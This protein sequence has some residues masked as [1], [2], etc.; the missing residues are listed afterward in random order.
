MSW[1]DIFKKNMWKG[2]GYSSSYFPTAARAAAATKAVARAVGVKAAPVARVIGS[3]AVPIIGKVAAGTGTAATATKGAVL[4]AGVAAG[5]SLVNSIGDPGFIL[6]IL[7]LLFWLG[8]FLDNVG[9]TL[10]L[11]SFLLFFTS[12]FIFK[13]K[14]LGFTVLVWIWFMIAGRPTDP[15]TIATM[16]LPAALVAMIAHGLYNKFS[17]EGTFWQGAFGEPMAGAI[18]LLIFFIDLG[19]IEW[20]TE[21][22]LGFPLP[23]SFGMIL[24]LVPWWAYLGLF[25][26]KKESFW[27]STIRVVGMIYLVAMVIATAQPTLAAYREHSLVPGAAE[28]LEAKKELRERLPQRENP[29]VSRMACLFGGDYSD[30]QGC[31]Q[32]RQEQYELNYICTKV[33]EKTKGTPEYDDCLKEQQEKKK[34]GIEV[35]GGQDP[36]RNQPMKAEFIVSQYFPKSSFRNPA[37]TTTNYPLEFKIEN[38]RKYAFEVELSCRFKKGGQTETL[39]GKIISEETIK[40]NSETS[41]TTV[42]CQAQNLEGNYQLVYEAK[43]KNLF[44]K[45]L[46]RRAFIGSKNETW[47]KEWLPRIMPAHFASN[48]HLSQAPADLARINF[49]LG[50]PLE[51]PIIELVEPKKSGLVL[52]AA[53]ENAGQGKITAINQYTLGLEGF[54]NSQVPCSKQGLNVAVPKDVAK[55]IYLTTCFIDTILIPDLHNPPHYEFREFGASLHYDYLLTKEIP[56]EVK[57]ITS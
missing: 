50:N 12:F 21:K 26:M 29:F 13:A 40:I 2:S 22:L 23:E 11:T 24:S 25:T 9:I 48:Q 4:G 16:M 31:I 51:N 18:P 41:G 42:I 44:T 3:R 30:L 32:Q 5:A 54:D 35:S 17:K 1:K 27:I 6:F 19:A 10:I 55:S 45:S 14:G 38:P 33:E 47:K 52:S 7:G 20:F 43:L 15:V 53:V 37:E 56:V 46:L 39:P 36:T 8:N 34:Q 49:A 28:F 57:V